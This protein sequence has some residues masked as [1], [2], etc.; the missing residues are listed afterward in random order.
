MTFD[1]IITKLHLTDPTILQALHQWRLQ[2]LR[3]KWKEHSRSKVLPCIKH[4][5]VKQFSEM[6]WGRY[7]NFINHKNQ[8]SLNQ[9]CKHH[10]KFSPPLQQK[11]TCFNL[12]KK[13]G[14]TLPT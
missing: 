12:T 9:K 6:H 4:A 11:G 5:K 3:G 14:N 2:P 1:Q 8:Q 7:H 10:K 13:S